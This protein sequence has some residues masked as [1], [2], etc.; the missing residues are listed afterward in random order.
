MAFNVTFPDVVA[1]GDSLVVAVDAQGGA[2][3]A[4]GLSAASQQVDLTANPNVNLGPVNAAGVFGVVIQT[5]NDSYS[6]LVTMLSSDTGFT[7][8]HDAVGGTLDTPIPIFD[9]QDDGGDAIDHFMNALTLDMFQEAAAKAWHDHPSEIALA[10]GT[11]VLICFV[12]GAVGQFE[13]V[14]DEILETSAAA[15]QMILE[16]LIDVMVNDRK[17][18]SAKD[19]ATLSKVISITVL[20]KGLAEFQK[21]AD[22]LAKMDVAAGAADTVNDMQN[23]DDNSRMTVKTFAGFFHRIHVLVK[24][25]QH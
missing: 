16:S 10:A 9:V 5:A 25:G 8:L 21:D 14:L 2:L 19:G 6:A 4:S 18:L 11:S 15:A 17:V 13:I 1:A 7:I 22:F 12:A 23:P 3:V 24:I 20:I